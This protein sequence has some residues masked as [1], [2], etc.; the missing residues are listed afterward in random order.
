MN[1]IP[2]E[3]VANMSNGY[4]A[5]LMQQYQALTGVL[6]T[7]PVENF[8]VNLGA[9]VEATHSTLTGMRADKS[10][11]DYV[12]DTYLSMRNR[13]IRNGLRVV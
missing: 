13:I 8:S 2:I 1:P 3:E 7:S 11:P 5:V 4:H 12:T 10:I 9:I 6:E